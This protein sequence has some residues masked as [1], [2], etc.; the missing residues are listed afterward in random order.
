ML[1]RVVAEQRQHQHTAGWLFLRDRRSVNGT[2]VN[3][4]APCV[5]IKDFRETTN[6]G[7]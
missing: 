2:V 7:T 6:V 3:Y 1:H 4:A 5:T